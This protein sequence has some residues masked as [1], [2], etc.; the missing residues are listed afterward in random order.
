MMSL[1]DLRRHNG[2]EHNASLAHADAE[3]DHE[4]APAEH[5]EELYAALERHSGDGKSITIEEFARARIRRELECS[6]VLDPT[7]A[8]IARGEVALILDIFGTAHRRIDLKTMSNIWTTPER[9]PRGWKPTHEQTL[10][11]TVLTAQGIK[12]RMI[13]F[14]QGTEYK[15]NMIQKFLKVYMIF[16]EP[17]PSNNVCHLHECHDGAHMQGCPKSWRNT[18]SGEGTKSR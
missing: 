16:C 9:F 4:Y 6:G 7:H 12:Q 5:D 11:R 15:Q 13:A 10:A 17:P 1:H 18:Q 8:E 3:L 14:R 2:I